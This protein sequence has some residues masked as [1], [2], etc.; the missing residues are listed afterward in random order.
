MFS[1]FEYR[2]SM[3]AKLN[4][5]FKARCLCGESTLLQSQKM[6]LRA[7]SSILGTSA[8]CAGGVKM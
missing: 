6:F 1:I 4:Q 2:Q 8:G 3:S 7:T 5:A